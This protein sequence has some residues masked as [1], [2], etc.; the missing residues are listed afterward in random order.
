MKKYLLPKDGNFYKANLHV[1]STYSDGRWM[2]KEIKKAYMEKGYSIIAFTDHNI[3]IPHHDL[4]DDEFLALTGV[5]IDIDEG[6]PTWTFDPCLHF[7]AIALD[8]ENDVQPCWH[9]SDYQCQNVVYHKHEVKFDESQPDYVRE[10]TIECANDMMK[11]F[12]DKGF[13]VTYNHPS[14][15]L[16]TYP[17]YMSYKHF[18][19]MEICNSG[20]LGNGYDE[21][22]SKEYDDM[23]RSGKR[24]FAIAADD[25]HMRGTV[26]AFESFTAI[27]AEKLEYKNVT[28]ALMAGN[29]YSSQ[30]PEI[31]DLWYEDGFVHIT[32]PPSREAFITKGTRN[33]K[34]V[35]APE[36]EFITEASFSI[37]QGD[38]YFRITVEAHDGKRA[39][40]NAYFID[41]IL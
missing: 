16:E 36:G 25:A 35:K 39:W 24:V 29:F 9:R 41:E 10:C 40:T 18:H 17:V 20:S 5:E 11:T 4:T 31:N 30:G 7:C 15:S 37:E 34:R 22:N 13:F 6:A 3:L 23:L 14:W 1:H 21:I 28:D 33:A 19:A 8:P 2:P 32:F 27:K 26:D 12:V 38:V